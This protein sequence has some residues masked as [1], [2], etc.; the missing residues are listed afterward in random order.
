MDALS[1]SAIDPLH[2][3]SGGGTYD[4]AEWLS[5]PADARLLAASGA[6]V[7]FIYQ[8]GISRDPDVRVQEVLAPPAQAFQ[9][10]LLPR[11]RG[12]TSWFDGELMRKGAPDRHALL[13]PKGVSS[14]WVTSADFSEAIHLHISDRFVDT[15]DAD[16][17][18]AAR[19][20]SGV[21][22][23]T[24]RGAAIYDAVVH[25][26]RL[27]RS[28]AL[29]A[30][31][32]ARLLLSDL[33][34]KPDARVSGLTPLQIRRVREFIV[35]ALDRPIT[36]AD[37]ARVAGLSASHFA[38]AF[39]TSLGTTPAAYVERLRMEQAKHQLRQGVPIIE[40]GVAAGY[41]SQTAFG[42]AFKRATGLSPGAWRRGLE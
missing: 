8:R 35:E 30:E 40:A 13:V 26:A 7:D 12:L 11:P 29:R 32:F 38:R 10:L 28:D 9:L 19:L 34:S 21:I 2:A 14:R 4:R 1:D 18:G 42:A 15:L 5:T 36:I 24:G 31:A 37:M 25:E 20:P 16:A 6:G 27:G 33:T 23:V 41:S 17:P 22:D 3:D 39:G